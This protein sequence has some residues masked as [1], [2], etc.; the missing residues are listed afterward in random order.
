MKK[1]KKLLTSL[2]KG[3]NIL[4]VA[5][6]NKDNLETIQVVVL[7][8]KTIHNLNESNKNKEIKKS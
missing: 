7:A 1:M 2:L 4:T 6:N 3:G 5:E 8:E